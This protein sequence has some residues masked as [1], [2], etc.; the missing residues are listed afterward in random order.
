MKKLT[1]AAMGIIALAALPVSAA[2]WSDTYLGYQY[3]NQFRDPGVSGNEVK[4]RTELSGIYGWDYG[5]NFFDVNMLWASHKDP[6]NDPTYFGNAAPNVPGDT[7]VYCVYRSN[8]DLGK[9]FKTNMAFGPVREVDLTVG[10]D[11]DSTDNEFASNKKFV[12]AGPQFGF[13]ITKGFWNVGVG[14]CREQNYNGFIEHEVD[15][16]TT[17]V[18]WT[19]WEKSFDLG[20]PV[21]WKGWANYIGSK[22]N[23]TPGQTPP[24]NTGTK[25]ETI[26]DTYV[27]FDISAAFGRKKGAIFIGPGFEFWN[28]KFGAPNKTDYANTFGDNN[29][30]VHAIMYCAEFH[31]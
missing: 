6:A 4:Q 15:F 31:F 27:M 17:G 21:A 26:G 12:V 8:F 1:L 28:N 30:P 10:F 14:V 29:Q 16:K 5:T 2:N 11:F 20:V 25:P 13:N 18:I 22:G 9:I 3:S 7:E 24:V 19:A 23:Q